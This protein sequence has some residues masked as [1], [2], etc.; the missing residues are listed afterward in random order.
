MERSFGRTTI[1]QDVV[2]LILIFVLSGCTRE[3][4]V[5][6]AF[7]KATPNY[8]NWIKRTDST[9][10]LIN[11]YSLSIDSALRVLDECSGLILTGG[12]DIYPGNY[13]R[14][15]DTGKC[16]GFDRYRD[17]LELMLISK[18]FELKMPV[19]GICR[20]NQILNVYLGGKLIINIPSDFNKPVTHQCEDYL[21]CFHTVYIAPKTVLRQITK[22]DSAPVTTNHHQAIQMLS[23]MLREN[24]WSGDG[25][26]EGIEWRNP[27]G[28]SFLIG[29]QW[30]PER[31][32]KT[33]GLSGN[34][35][36]EFIRQAKT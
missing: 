28:K 13:G 34:L 11:L 32:E 16:T 36:G 18:A 29:V 1:I 2:F 26:I 12:E 25:L 3:K 8:T 21:H 23:P 19:V 4:P 31:M 15:C 17:T 27:N 24:A 22:C 6:I 35:A 5:K 10:I 7:S 9:L 33:N 14:E 30:H 20:G